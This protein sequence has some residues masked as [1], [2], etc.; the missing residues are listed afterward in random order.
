MTIN[1]S[2][3]AMQMGTVRDHHFRATIMRPS[4]NR[5]DALSQHRQRETRLREREET[6][7]EASE[8]A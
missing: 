3:T 5:N 1:F 8:V 6:H 2:P 4:R 7:I